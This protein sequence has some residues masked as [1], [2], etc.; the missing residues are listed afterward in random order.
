MADPDGRPCPFCGSADTQIFEDGSGL[1]RNCGR[2]FRGAGPVGTLL[3]GEQAARKTAVAREKVGAG[4]LA[5]VGSLLGL[6]GVPGIFILGAVLHG[7]SVSDWTA[8][9][10]NQQTG[11]LACGGASL[12]GIFS[13][14]ALWAGLFVWRGFPEKGTHL[15]VGGALMAVAAGIGGLG[16]AGAVGIAGGVLV[17]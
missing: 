12:L 2:A 1:C 6:A 13:V 17:L 16:V 9:V 11:A 4:R 15:L 7:R 8:D 10:F 5:F 14:Y 3:A